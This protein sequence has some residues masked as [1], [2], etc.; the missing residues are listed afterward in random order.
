M[1]LAAAYQSLSKESF[2]HPSCR[3]QDYAV[4]L[5]IQFIYLTK[6]VQVLV[7]NPKLLLDYILKVLINKAQVI[8]LFDKADLR[9]LY[10]FEPSILFQV[11][12][13]FW[14][15]SDHSILRE[16][17]RSCKYIEAL[18]LLDKF[19]RDMES[20]K[21]INI[22]EFPLPVVTSQMAPVD[23]KEHIHTVLAI[24]CKKPYS[25]CT[26]MNVTEVRTALFTTLNFNRNGLQLLGVLNNGSEFTLMYWMIPKSVIS[27]ITLAVTDHS[28]IA[29]LYKKDITEVSIYP[30]L[31]FSTGD[32]I[33]VGPL[34]VLM[35]ISSQK[36]KVSSK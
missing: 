5:N 3:H 30:N 9:W 14:T 2:E 31:H 16:V 26:W 19:D 27:L 20:F 25:Q 22:E 18:K 13:I 7:Q 24:K 15:W 32:K 28:K 12:C 35:D 11:L 1:H 21:S 34:A 10:A 17:L 29:D 4:G 36:T 6:S 8:K 23:V 33:R